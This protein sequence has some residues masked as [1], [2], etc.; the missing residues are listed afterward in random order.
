LG[1]LS[2]S[3]TIYRVD[4]DPG[5]GNIAPKELLMGYD[6]LLLSAIIVTMTDQPADHTI[7]GMVVP[8][9]PID[10]A[11]QE[12]TDQPPDAPLWTLEEAATALEITVNAVRQRLKRG[13]LTGIKTN[14][15]WLV[16][17]VATNQRPATDRPSGRPTN[18]ATTQAT[19]QP[20]I[21]LAPLVSH[22]AALEDQVQRLTEASTMWQIRA[23][24]AEEQLKQLMAGNVVSDNAPQSNTVD[25]ERPQLLQESDPGPTGVLAWWKRLWG[26]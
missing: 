19:D 7:K 23:R 12:P 15:G 21:D 20:T 3:V 17:M 22:I 8:D 10:H 24:Q 11:G 13:T 18:H 2:L 6:A 26:D 5:P 14:N 1:R 25:A 4:S 16:D 9:Q